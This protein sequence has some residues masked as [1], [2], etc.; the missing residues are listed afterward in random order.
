MMQLQSGGRM[1]SSHLRSHGHSTREHANTQTWDERLAT[2]VRIGSRARV[3]ART[4]DARAA[5]ILTGRDRSI[6]M[7]AN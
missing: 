7:E 4:A 5:N 6:L 1:G 2:L 3:F